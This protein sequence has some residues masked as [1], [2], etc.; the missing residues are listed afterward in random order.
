MF[1][2]TATFL[3]HKGMDMPKRKAAV[4]FVH[5]LA[6]KP[7]PAKLRELWTWGLTQEGPQP[8][9]FPPPNPGIDLDALGRPQAY[10]YWAD[11]FYGE[12]YD[13]EYSSYYETADQLPEQV[14][15][16]EGLDIVDV[17]LEQREVLAPREQRFIARVEQEFAAK[18][19]DIEQG[20]IAN[21]QND[22]LEVARLLPSPLRKSIIRKAAKEAYYYLFDKPFVR[23]DKT[24]FQ[25]RKEIRRRFLLDLENASLAAEKVVV[26]SHSMGTMIAYDVLRNCPDC[27]SVDLL[28]TLGSPLGIAEIQ[29]ELKAVGRDS[30]DFPADRL[31]RWINIY[32]PLDPICGVDPRFANDYARV[33]GKSVEDI[34]EDNWGSWRHTI[35]H[36]LAGKKFRTVLADAIGVTR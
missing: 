3:P 8:T 17:E 7:S 2:R 31:S 18:F 12:D 26:V 24:V 27:P 25:V 5:G 28:I 6:R 15:L 36:Y 14:A 11:V 16:A 33:N 29:D 32:D 10:T 34:R 35:T 23:E 9:V 1:E 4:V 13:T 22:D 21:V 20:G 30:V 19:D